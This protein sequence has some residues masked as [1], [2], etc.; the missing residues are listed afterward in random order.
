MTPDLPPSPPDA[1]PQATLVSPAKPSGEQIAI[2][3]H[4]YY[5]VVSD[6]TL[7][8][9]DVI[10][11]S[12]APA[13]DPKAAVEALRQAYLRAGYF[14][15]AVRAEVRGKLV[16]LQV[17]QGRI[18]E[19]DMAPSLAPFYGGIAGRDDLDRNTVIR[20]SALAE[21]YAAR[22]GQRPKVSFSP[23]QQV[24]GS[25]ITVTEEP[26]PGARNWNAGLAFGD[27]GSRFSSRYLASANA[28]V[29]PGSGIELTAGYAQGLPGLSEAS[30]GST[31]HA[32]SLG[33]TAVTPWGL[34][35]ATT[36]DTKYRIGTA[37]APVN[38][39]GK[40]TTYGANGTQLVY[41]NE[42]SRWA[43]NES[44]THTDNVVTGFDGLFTITEQ[45]Y[46]F[47]SVGT[48]FGTSVAAFG[49]AAGVNGGLTISK[50][51]SPREGTFL[52]DEPGRANPGFTIYQANVG[53]TQPLPQG[54][55]AALN[56]NGQWADATVP[57]NQQ[58]VLGGLGNLTAWLPAVLIGDMGSLARASVSMPAREWMGVTVSGGVFVEGGI[59]RSY[60]TLP[61]VPVTRGLA[62]AGLNVSASLKGGTSLLLAY[63]WPIASRNLDPDALDR[64]DRSHLY[65]SLN[66]AF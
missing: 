58:W 56:V 54:F 11:A 52:P 26:I 36:T 61:G 38:P 32:L 41:A 8:S 29:R 7:L 10:L 59:A 39:D 50:G 49:Q 28:A 62:D 1:A 33:V 35:G 47:V 64:L 34:Y 18:T 2:E 22:Q 16:A 53:Y 19:E 40:I 60:Y 45:H 27:L 24:G 21:A 57:Q 51:L 55:S 43:I 44:F 37:A 17:I 23:A 25:K 20:K 3:S 9:R 63:A 14:M 30:Q 6:N 13:E 15:A 65:F 12:L 66:Q 5:Y 48:T 46:D 31:Y 42:V 4:G